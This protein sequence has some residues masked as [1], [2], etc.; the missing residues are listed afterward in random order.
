M[1]IT[2]MR[3]RCERRDSPVAVPRLS[4]NDTHAEIRG[5]RGMSQ[6]TNRYKI[7]PRLS[8]GA[9]ILK[10]DAART[11]DRNTPVGVL[12]IE[13]GTAFDGAAYVFGRHVIEQNSLGTMSEC[14]L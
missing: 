8:V 11:F 7:D 2:T 1:R 10:A 3:M 9:N 6:E 14:L 5:V 13:T 4:G 12:G